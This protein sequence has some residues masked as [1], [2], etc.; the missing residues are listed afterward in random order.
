MRQTVSV[1]C[2]HRNGCEPVCCVSLIGTSHQ[3][4][5]P[6]SSP[7]PHPWCADGKRDR[8]PKLGWM[9][10]P[11]MRSTALPDLQ[12]DETCQTRHRKE[13]QTANT[14]VFNFVTTF[15]GEKQVRL[16]IV[17]QLKLPERQISNIHPL[18]T[19]TGLYVVV[20]HVFLWLVLI[21]SLSSFDS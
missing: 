13:R 3:K 7:S 11:F 2:C 8:P 12:A 4:H 16:A 10:G 14:S 5:C 6:F 18:A 20:C 21:F 17:G 15:S 1:N 19:S 9:L